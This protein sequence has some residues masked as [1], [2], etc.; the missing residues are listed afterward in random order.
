[1]SPRPRTV[2]DA[3][4]LAAAA[5]MVGRLGPLRMTLAD[6]ATEVGLA[7][8]TLVQRFG[9]KRGLLLALARGGMGD[10][11]EEKP[12]APPRRPGSP[13]AAIHAMGAGMAAMA[14]TPEEMS[15]HLAFLQIDLT[16]PEFHALALRHGQATREELHALLDQAVAAG[17]LVPCDTA[18]LARTVQTALNGS[19]L[20]WAIFREGPAP[21]WV[22][23]D[24]EAV[25]APYRMEAG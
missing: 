15:N 4:I 23:D 20:M 21:A 14:R 7:P 12:S 1:M 25:L 16:D 3:D 6:V 10:G 11:D 17:E 22:R 24:L 8:A 5:R 18:R 9:S 19:M 13:L 2:S